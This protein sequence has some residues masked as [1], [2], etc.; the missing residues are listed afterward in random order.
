V[1]SLLSGEGW[2]PSE[3]SESKSFEDSETVKL[4]PSLAPYHVW[5]NLTF[6][7]LLFCIDRSFFSPLTPFSLLV[8]KIWESFFSFGM[9]RSSF[10][11]YPQSC[12]FFFPL[13]AKRRFFTFHVVRNVVFLF[14]CY[15]FIYQ[16]I[17]ERKILFS[18]AFLSFPFHIEESSLSL[19]ER[20][21]TLLGH[22]P[23]LN[24]EP[25]FWYSFFPFLEE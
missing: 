24:F 9:V 13:Q 12:P 3:G 5:R 17:M 4:G 20:I 22:V 25:F 2:A 19:S 23:K 18:P 10:L 8:K 16:I 21:R 15:P 1:R 6:F 14:T 11:F 7:L